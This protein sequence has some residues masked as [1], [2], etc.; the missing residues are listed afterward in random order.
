MVTVNKTVQKRLDKEEIKISAITE[1]IGG[2]RAQL[3]E[4][5]GDLEYVIALYYYNKIFFAVVSNLIEEVIYKD[6]FCANNSDDHIFMNDFIKS[7]NFKQVILRI[8]CIL[9]PEAV[10]IQC[11]VIKNED[12]NCVMNYI[13]NAVG[14]ENCPKIIVLE[15]SRNMD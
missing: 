15:P 9:N 10:V 5:N 11:E 8:V 6:E 14:K 7:F 3:F 4:I 12:I 13:S 1:S 2:R